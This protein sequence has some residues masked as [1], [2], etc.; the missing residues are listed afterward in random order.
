[1]NRDTELTWIDYNPEGVIDIIMKRDDISRE[2]AIHLLVEC[3][4]NKDAQD[5]T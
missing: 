1:M 3:F 4:G 5:C 2:D